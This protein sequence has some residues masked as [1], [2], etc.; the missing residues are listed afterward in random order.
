MDA[1]KIKLTFA[2][3][4]YRIISRHA[5]LAVLK[6]FDWKRVASLTMDDSKYSNYM[7]SL[8]DVLQENGIEF[9]INRKF[10]WDTLDMSLVK[11]PTLMLHFC[12]SGL[13]KMTVTF[14]HLTFRIFERVSYLFEMFNS[15]ST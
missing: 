15:S 13:R 6:K 12:S 9:I 8:Q 4:T 5:Y 7:S 3:V 1:F 14:Q 2:F 11:V 10:P